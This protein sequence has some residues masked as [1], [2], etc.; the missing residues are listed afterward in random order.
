M[1]DEKIRVLI[2]DD[3]EFQAVGLKYLLSYSKEI[4]V[5]GICTTTQ[6]TIEMVNNLLPDLIMLDLRWNDNVEPGFGLIRDIHELYPQVAIMVMTHHRE[7]LNETRQAGSDMSFDKGQLSN[8]ES[9]V[10]LIKDTLHA[11][12]MNQLRVPPVHSDDKLTERESEVLEQLCKGKTNR[13][14]AEE[15]SISIKTVKT[16]VSKIL[17]KLGVSNRAEAIGEALRRGLV[18]LK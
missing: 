11:H 4:S 16:H 13:D 6:K 8:T 1:E 14:I 5:V 18:K 10:N 2:A 7:Y 3:Q 12:R 9:I 15:L 17:P